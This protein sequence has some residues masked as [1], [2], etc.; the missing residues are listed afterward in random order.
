MRFEAV[1]VSPDSG[2]SC[3]IRPIT[4]FVQRHSSAFLVPQETAMLVKRRT[5]HDRYAC[6]AFP[7]DGAFCGRNTAIAVW[8]RNASASTPLS[9]GLGHAY[10]AFLAAQVADVAA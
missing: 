10:A 8:G 7:S 1:P 2:L 4:M 9:E 6:T 5:A 3:Y